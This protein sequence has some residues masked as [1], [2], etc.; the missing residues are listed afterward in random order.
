MQL[1]KEKKISLLI[2]TPTLDDKISEKDA[3]KIRR[4]SVEFNI[5]CITSID[6]AKALAFALSSQK[7]EKEIKIYQ[8]EKN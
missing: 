8:L 4:A 3:T 1:V 2:N 5:P 6:T 7:K